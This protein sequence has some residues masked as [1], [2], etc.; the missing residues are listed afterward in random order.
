MIGCENG[1]RFDVSKYRTV[2]LLPPKAPRTI[3]DDREMLAARAALLDSALY[4]PIASALRDATSAWSPRGGAALPRI[5]DFGSGTG[6]Y[7]EVVATAH[8]GSPVLAADRSP[9]AVRMS[10]RA[11]EGATGVVLDIWR[12]LP[13]RDDVVDIALNIFAPRNPAEYARVIRARGILVVVVPRENHLLE[14]QRSGSMLTIPEGKQH[15][16]TSAL[17]AAGFALVGQV[18]VEYTGD[19]DTAQRALLTAMGPTAHHLP[20]TARDEAEQIGEHTTVTVAVDV[21]TFALPPDDVDP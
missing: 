21:L 7:T 12:P 16:V 20:T 4:G 10:T 13:L 6:Y 17:A 2:T 18:P 3:G 11:V 8:E 14:L 9:T 5:A 15:Q 1:H 19:V